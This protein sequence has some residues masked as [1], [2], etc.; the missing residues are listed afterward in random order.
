MKKLFVLLVALF[1]FSGLALAV[2]INSADQKEL[3]SIKGIGPVK[4][5]AIV[6][7]RKKNGAFKSVDDLANVKGMDAKTVG[8]LKN[9]LTAGGTGEKMGPVE[10]SKKADETM[11]KNAPRPLPGK[12]SK[13]GPVE[14][15]GEAKGKKADET[16]SKDAPRKY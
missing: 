6:D 2:D 13:P 12:D 15:S 3:E 10:A 1:A 16:M 11:S 4:A 7:H 9:E 5:K 8:K 14:K